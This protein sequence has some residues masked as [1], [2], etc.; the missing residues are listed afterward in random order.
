MAKISVQMDPIQLV[1]IK[2]DT[3]F[4]LTLEAY[5]RGHELFYYN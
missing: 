5:K 3:S 4:S 2:A 1:D